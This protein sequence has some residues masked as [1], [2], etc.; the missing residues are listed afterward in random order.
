MPMISE[1]PI[2]SSNNS[3]SDSTS[4]T[5]V[6]SANKFFSKISNWA[7]GIAILNRDVSIVK[8]IVNNENSSSN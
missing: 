3:F 8:D 7:S 1:P 5:S 4:D 2:I 6:L